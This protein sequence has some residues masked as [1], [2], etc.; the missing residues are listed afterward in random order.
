M[1]QGSGHLPLI[2]FSNNSRTRAMHKRTHVNQCGH[3]HIGAAKPFHFLAAI[4][5]LGSLGCHATNRK[6]VAT[7]SVVPPEL[8]TMPRELAKTVLPEYVIEPPDILK[9]S[10]A[11]PDDVLLLNVLLTHNESR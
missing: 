1:A 5:V 10:F 9:P 7:T 2:S 11:L 3:H 8:S 6:S 4:L